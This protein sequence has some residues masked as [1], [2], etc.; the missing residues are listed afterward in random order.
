[1]KCLHCLILLTSVV[2]S[3]F[4]SVYRDFDE[5]VKVNE[6]FNVPS[7][8]NQSKT[9][10]D[11]RLRDEAEFFMRERLNLFFKKT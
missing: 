2:S 3:A 1:M 9:L 10:I 5:I 8:Y 7:Q 6:T 4:A 11:C